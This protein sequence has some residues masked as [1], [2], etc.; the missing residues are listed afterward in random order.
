MTDH[1]AKYFLI[2]LSWWAY[3]KSFSKIYPRV[4]LLGDRYAYIQLY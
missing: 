4:E 3:A 2:Q 1:P